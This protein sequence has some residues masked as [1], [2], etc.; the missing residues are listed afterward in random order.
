[1]PKKEIAPGKVIFVERFFNKKDR[2][3]QN[4]Q[5][6]SYYQKSKSTM[7]NT[8]LFVKFIPLDVTEVQFKELFSQAGQVDSVKLVVKTFKSPDG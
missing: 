5:P 7:N 3:L 2:D 6:Q 8:N 4:A 1:M